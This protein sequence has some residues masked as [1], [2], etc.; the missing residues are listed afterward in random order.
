MPRLLLLLPEEECDEEEESVDIPPLLRSLIFRWIVADDDAVVDIVVVDDEDPSTFIELSSFFLFNG[1]G[2]FAE[3]G[4]MMM[5]IGKTKTRQFYFQT[6]PEKA[7][8]IL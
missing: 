7:A 4:V 3:R 6:M 8:T 1:F 5:M 2:S